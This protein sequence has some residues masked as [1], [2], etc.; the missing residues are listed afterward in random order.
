MNRFFSFFTASI[1]LLITTSVFS[2]GISDVIRY[3]EYT[4]LGTARTVGVGSSFGAM[5]GD[6]SVI[7]INPAGIATYRKSEFVLTP[8]LGGTSSDAFLSGRPE[9][10]R[11]STK[12]SFAIDNIGLVSA[13]Q[14]RSATW[15]TSNFAIG[16]SKLKDFGRDFNF[17]GASVGSISE[18]WVELAR[19]NNLDQLDDFEAWP[20][21][22]AG[23]LI[24]NGDNT[25][26]TD[27]FRDDIVLKEQVVQQSGY[28]NELSLAWAGSYKN[29]LNLGVSVGVP[30]VSYEETKEYTEAVD[31]RD[32]NGEQVF[33]NNLTYREFLNTT[34][35]GINFKLG[36]IYTPVKMLRLGASIHSP[37]WYALND[38]FDTSV[39]YQFEYFT[40]PTS[41]GVGSQSSI[42]GNF[43]YG[44]TSPWRFV[45]S[46]GSIYSVGKLQ[47]FVNADIEFLDYTSA[48]LNLT[49]ESRN[50]EDVE[51]DREANALIDQELARATNL[52]LGTE[53]AY[54]LSDDV[55]LRLRLGYAL[56][57][58][59][60][61][62]EDGF[63]A[64]W[65]AGFGL[66]FQGFFVDVGYRRT[67][68]TEGYI[69]YAAPD[70]GRDPLT[71]IDTNRGRMVMTLGF[72]F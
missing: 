51:A 38:D 58:S 63:N 69:A 67:N 59:P 17:S 36:M 19:G 40:E 8:S 2:Q 66:R 5:G 61:F 33:A 55:G 14:P 37:T 52:R 62:R 71:E 12:S 49:R 6:F 9:E 29:K 57:A 44:M 47:G 24:D 41:S 64:F 15:T 68:T 3:S 31:A 22:A 7:G 70:I 34:G 60:F 72:K 35:T 46:V 13:S 21:F 18:R 50:I 1:F 32:E 20:A 39:D 30:F 10:S 26:S 4:P 48:G 54:P 45:G 65:S 53:V 16:L 56:S 28:I 42:D 43:S 11:S 25:Y 23:V 27:Y